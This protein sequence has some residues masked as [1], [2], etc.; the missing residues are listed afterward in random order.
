MREYKNKSPYP[1][2]PRRE[3]NKHK[4]REWDGSFTVTD[5]TVRIPDIQHKNSG[6]SFS[7]SRGRPSQT[8]SW[9]GIAC[10]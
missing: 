6:S 10:P 4:Y 8:G 7:S 5:V 3:I 1:T 9:A 2:P